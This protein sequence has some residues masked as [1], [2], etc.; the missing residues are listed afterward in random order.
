VRA[1]WTRGRGT[2]LTRARRIN[3][4][5]TNPIL[6]R[7]P[8]RH[9]L[10]YRYRITETDIYRDQSADSSEQQPTNAERVYD[11]HLP[12]TSRKTSTTSRRLKRRS[13]AQRVAAIAGGDCRQR[14]QPASAAQ[15][16][17]ASQWVG[18][19]QQQAQQSVVVERLD[20]ADAP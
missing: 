17:A 6:A 4:C 9:G 3:A 18:L 11:T 14:G 16:Q 13:A 1:A 19:F 12:S 8:V 15:G 20:Q 2:V 5:W 7:R 10:L